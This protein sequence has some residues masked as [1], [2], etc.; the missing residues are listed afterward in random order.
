MDGEACN[1]RCSNQGL[2]ITYALLALQGPVAEKVLQKLTDEPLAEIKFFR[3]KENVNINGHEVLISRT[4]YTGEDGFE[5][6][7]SPEA[8]VDLWPAILQQ[9]KVKVLYPQ[10]LV[11][12]THF[13][14]KQV[15]HFMDKNYQRILHHLKLASICCEAEQRRRL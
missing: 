2:I 14:L 5:I 11:H 4:G 13:V 15:C 10:D 6:Y 7:G 12:V 1:G 9:E 3:F 8:I